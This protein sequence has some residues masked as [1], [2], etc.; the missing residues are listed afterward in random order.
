MRAGAYQKHAWQHHGRLYSQPDVG[1]YRRGHACLPTRP[2]LP[3]FF[4]Q[5]VPRVMAGPSASPA[6]LAASLRAATQATRGLC[7]QR[8]LS[9]PTRL[10]RAQQASGCAGLQQVVCM[11]CL[12]WDMCMVHKASCCLPSRFLVRVIFYS[13]QLCLACTPQVTVLEGFYEGS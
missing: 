1:C 7:A 12:I 11:P 13:P 6:A 4:P 3:T 8:A 2:S 10:R 9:T 5:C